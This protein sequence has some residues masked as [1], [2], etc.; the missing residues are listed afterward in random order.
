M[1]R[2]RTGEGRAILEDKDIVYIISDSVGETADLVVKAVAT[3][4]NGGYV[5]I[6]RHSHVED[7]DDIEDVLHM[8]S[9]AGLYYC[10]YNCDSS[11]KEYLD[12][13]AKEE[14]IMAVDLL[15]S[16]HGSVYENV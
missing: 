16:T 15:K 12:R 1:L 5:E 2:F 14:G 7:F 9:I 13:R 10:L 6:K 3:Q 8:A 11:L 4:F